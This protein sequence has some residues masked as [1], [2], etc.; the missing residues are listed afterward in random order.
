MM[1]YSERKNN[2][3]RRKEARP[4]FGLLYKLDVGDLSDREY[5]CYNSF[6]DDRL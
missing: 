2:K 1:I 3:K 4:L 5:L 6:N